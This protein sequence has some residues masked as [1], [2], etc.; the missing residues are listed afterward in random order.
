MDNPWVMKMEQFTRFTPAEKQRLTQLVSERQV[1]NAAGDDIISEG[2]HSPDCHVVLSGLA[3]RYKMLPDGERQ[4]MAFLVP[5]D[6]CDAEIF[7]LKEMDHS[8]GAMAPTTTALI[9]GKVMRALL[10]EQGCIAEALW[11]GTL[12]DLGVLRERIIDH[13]RRDARERIAHL[14]YE[15]LVRY[16]MVGLTGDDVFDFPITQ[17]D[18]ADATG[19]TPVHVN[20]TLKGLRDDNLVEFNDGKVLVHDVPGL[21]KLAAFNGNY[22]HL[23]R[24]HDR[25]DG[26]S[27]RAGD[28][29]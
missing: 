15:M 23:D 19:L 20:R 1:E 24:V 7:I 5:G 3:C 12:T 18:L 14:L 22:L 29:V 21:K 9:S 2:D 16:R 27:G 6:L 10:R 25:R 11:W 17:Q 8:V 4:I 13:G 26:V 28:L